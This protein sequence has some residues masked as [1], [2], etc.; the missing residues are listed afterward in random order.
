MTTCKHATELLSQGLDRKLSLAERLRLRAHLLI[1]SGC[2]NAGRHFRF[3]REAVRQHPWHPDADSR[4]DDDSGGTP[5]GRD[6]AGK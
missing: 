6:E 2:R 4:S 5:S 1:C 3:L